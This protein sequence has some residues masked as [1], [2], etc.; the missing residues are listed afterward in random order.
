MTRRRKSIAIVVV[1]LMVLLAAIF[2]P[3]LI[4][5]LDASADTVADAQV[6]AADAGPLDA[7]AVARGQVVAVAADCAAC[8]TR[9]NGGASYAGGYGLQTP[10]GEIVTTN[11]TPDRKT[12]IGEW[13]E[14]DFFR[15]V[16]HGRTPN[17]FLYPAMPYTAYVQVSDTDMHDLWS[18]VRS[19]PAVASTGEGTH[20]PFPFSIRTL[21]AGWNMLFFDNRPFKPDAGQ[22]AEWN[23]GRYLV[24]SLGHCA[25]CHTPKNVL[26]GDKGGAYLRGGSLQGWFAPELSS[27]AEHGLGSWTAPQIAEY[28]KTG[29]NAHAVAAGPMAEAVEHSTQFMPDTDLAA[30]ST[31]LKTLPGTAGGNHAALAATDPVMQRGAHIYASQCSACHTAGGAGIPGMA[32][33]LSNNPLVRAPDP[34]SLIHVVLKGG[35]AAA[36]QSNP[37][38]AGMPA[39]AWKLSD[40]DAA[41][42]LTYVRNA[43]GNAAPAV[44]KT[45]VAALRERLS[46]RKAM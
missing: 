10:F 30:I 42:V 27:G 37:T 41:A 16:R 11:I 44:T 5:S 4:R 9:P 31:Y 3:K 39:F 12:G 33:R 14:R 34:T 13:T 21:V 18:Y 38:A 32:T 24:D 29:T 20:L 36:T 46:A 25:A 45:Q 26:G 15:A 19:L 40:D 17:G 7:A 22:S 6:K 28:L 2:V 43:N 1:A 23:R 8:H 35:R